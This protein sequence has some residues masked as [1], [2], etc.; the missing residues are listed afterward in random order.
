MKV[1]HY[2]FW[3]LLFATACYQKPAAKDFGLLDFDH[4]VDEQISQ[5]S[6]HRNSLEKEAA[7]GAH[8][9]DST[10]VPTPEIWK[11]EL[12][13]FRRL[14]LIN[15]P[16]HQDAYRSEGPLDDPR[17]NLK[18]QQ[19]TSDSSPL[20]VLRIYYHQS[21]ERV[22]RIEGV[23]KESNQLYASQRSLT[24]EFDEVAGRPVLTGYEIDGYQKVAL[25]DTVHFSV[26]G[27]IKW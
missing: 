2:G 22:R 3:L 5:L 17:S 14:Q 27:K 16:I 19:Y 24:M 10:L 25:R 9:S 23:L 12:D 21:I 20:I 8:R 7:V 26:L 13:I 4:L 1:S 18:I 11:T 15:K 6:Q